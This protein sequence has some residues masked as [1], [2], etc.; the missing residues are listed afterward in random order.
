MFNERSSEN[1]PAKLNFKEYFK[2]DEK[3]KDSEWN[4]FWFITFFID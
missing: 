3:H 1:S 2:M 4:Q